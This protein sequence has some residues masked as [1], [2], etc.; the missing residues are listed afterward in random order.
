MLTFIAAVIFLTLFL[1]LILWLNSLAST[2]RQRRLQQAALDIGASLDRWSPAPADLQNMNTLQQAQLRYLHNYLQTDSA[3]MFDFTTV[4][5]SGSTTQ[6]AVI[7]PCT[8]MDPGTLIASRRHWLSSDAMTQTRHPQYV[9]PDDLP[10]GLHNWTIQATPAHRLRQWL[11]PEV[12]DWLLAHPHLHIEWANGMLLVCQPGY[13]IDP[14]EI[15][16]VLNDVSRLCGALSR[17]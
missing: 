3:Q 4:T 8:R 2:P 9:A 7:M 6:T 16:L 5:D 15:T 1:G 14:A 13:L 10:P 17:P 11:S 12:T